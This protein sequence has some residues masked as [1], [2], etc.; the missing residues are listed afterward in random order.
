MVDVHRRGVLMGAGALGAG[1]AL[2]ACGSPRK[3]GPTA[4]VEIKAADVPVG[5]GLVVMAAEAVVTQPKPGQFH[6]FSALCTH[7]RCLVS[8]V[9]DGAINCPC[10][11]SRFSDVD[12]SVLEGPATAPLPAKQVTVNGASLTI[13]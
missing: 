9:L 7:M 1:A 11:G 10:H 5:G 2:T 8:T 6:A 13:S 4:P 12:G 3:A